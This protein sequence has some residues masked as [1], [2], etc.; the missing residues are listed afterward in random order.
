MDTL[1]V[2]IRFLETIDAVSPDLSD[3]VLS[4]TSNLK[5]MYET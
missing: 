3:K 5:R 4:P 1:R 2:F